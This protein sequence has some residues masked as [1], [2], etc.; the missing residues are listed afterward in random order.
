MIRK[1]R[2]VSF[3][4]LSAVCMMVSCTGNKTGH[5]NIEIRIKEMN[6]ENG[7]VIQIPEFVSDSEEIQKNLRDLEKETK[8]LEK[9][10]E[11]EQKKGNEIEMRCYT[12][13]SENYPQVTVVCF[14]EEENSR[15]YNL[16]T[17][18][19]DSRAGE[20]I[21]CKEALERTE[22]TGVDLSLSVGKLAQESGIRGE[23]A[24][25]EKQGFKLDESG[26]VEEIY[27]KLTMTIEE[28]EDDITEEH[29]FSYVL[30][31]EKL[32]KLSD[33]GYDVP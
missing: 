12:G 4:L 13:G 32:I 5:S 14:T 2:Y 15:L 18:A 33:K 8:D 17:L 27:M 31:D 11:K 9:I 26:N 10:V 24:S 28:E 30:R 20:A 19:A 7:A 22:M 29:F 23:Q 21:T 1:L 3:L 16:V 6:T 25:T